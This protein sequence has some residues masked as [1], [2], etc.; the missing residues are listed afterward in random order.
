[1]S[2]NFDDNSRDTS[3]WNL[4][5][6]DHNN[7]WLDETIQRLEFRST[8]DANDTAALYIANDWGFLPTADFS[9]KVDFHYSSIVAG[10][11]LLG[12]RKDEE[13]GENEVWLEAGYEEAADPYSAFFWDA[14]A[15]G[16][17]FDGGE[18]EQSRSLDDGTLYISYNA[19]TDDLYVSG[20]GYWADDAWDTISGLVQGAWGADMVSPL[21]GGCSGESYGALPSGVAYLDNFIVDS[22]TIVQICEYALAGDLN[23][24][25]KVDFRDLSILAAK[26]LV[27]CNDTPLDPSCRCDIPWVAEPPMNVA[28][29]QFAGGVIDGKIYVFGGNG[30]PDA[31]NLKST[32]MYDPAITDPN[33][34]PWTMVADNP[35]NP[36]GNGGVEELTAA[37]V[38]DK[39]YVF[40]AYGGLAPDGYYGVFNF[41]ETYDP[42]TNLWTILAPRPT[43][44]AAGPATVYNNEIYLFG[45][46]FDSDNPSQNYIDY[47]IV[48]CYDPNSN[49]WRFVT[50]MPKVLSNFGIATIGD[51]AYLFGGYDPNT[52]RLLDDVITYDFQTSIWD[53]SGYQPM[54]VRKGFMYSNSAPVIDGKVYL[55]GVFEE[56]GGEGVLSKRVDIYD[57]ATNTWE[58][59]TPLPLPLGDHVTL[60]IGGKI[61]L[62]G[63]DN[64]YDFYNRSKTEVISYDTDHCSH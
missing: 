10:S 50:N 15:D 22:G 59:G 64:N 40:G 1:P 52:V 12:I 5:E 55:I 49:T 62:V 47:D 35:H 56:G 32:E 28:R 20:R 57:P 29:D 7:A 6:D 60:S 8:A 38:N 39:L 46:C 25:C 27:N 48:E 37:V 4:Y 14:I 26:W 19:A 53:T 58:E 34:N 13:S 18:N 31:T 36:H 24:D 51:K 30:N 2:D 44:L 61:Y 43:T 42:A 3:L 16:N 63:G 23:N 45:G 9:F 54:P 17:Q 41:N 21:L 11:V 33:I